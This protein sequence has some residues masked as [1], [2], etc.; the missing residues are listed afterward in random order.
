MQRQ[1][2]SS[3]TQVGRV[4][5]GVGAALG[6]MTILCLV[7]AILVL[8]RAVRASKALPD[9]STS[10][11]ANEGT[12]GLEEVNRQEFSSVREYYEIADKETGYMEEKD[13]ES[14]TYAIEMRA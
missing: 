12:Q 1:H 2:Q 8:R 14:Q 13:Q 5:V 4:G 3:G 10:S 9:D 11:A 7:A 6:G